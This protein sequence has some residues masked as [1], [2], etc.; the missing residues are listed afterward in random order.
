[1]GSEYR[2]EKDILANEL[3]DGRLQKFGVCEHGQAREDYR[4]LTDG[5]NF[6]AVD[7][8]RWLCHRVRKS[9]E[10]HLGQSREDTIRCIGRLRNEDFSATREPE[11]YGFE[12]EE[13]KAAWRSKQTEIEEWLAIRKA[14]ALKIDPDTAEVDW[15][16]GQTLDPYGV[17]PE[18]PEE[19]QQV[20]REYFARASVAR[21]GSIL[22][23]C[24]KKRE[25]GCGLGIAVNWPFQ[26]GSKAFPKPGLKS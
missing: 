9:M 26:P 10:R 14:E 12:S 2:A 7:Q 6:I 4:C 20:G 8:R 13:Q 17:Y 19:Y 5:E 11:Y 24:P 21:S 22:A 18:L 1:M 23:T 15:E 16:Y 25:I 3:F